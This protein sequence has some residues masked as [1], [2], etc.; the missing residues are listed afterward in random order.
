MPESGNLALEA[1]VFGA[2]LHEL[3]LLG[4]ELCLGFVE[5][6][7][8]SG[9]I[10]LWYFGC[11]A[12]CC[13][14]GDANLVSELVCAHLHAFELV[15][16]PL[17]GCCHGFLEGAGFRGECLEPSLKITKV[18]VTLVIQL[19]DFGIVPSVS[20]FDFGCDTAH[21][22]GVIALEVFEC[23]YGLGESFFEARENIQAV[24]GLHV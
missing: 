16:G 14:F 21:T 6:V 18:A 23:C 11:C 9:E 19:S 5:R 2:E 10:R 20:G 12:L 24:L 1:F 22:V 17:C 7:Y 15:L 3:V 13:L 4:G 8:F